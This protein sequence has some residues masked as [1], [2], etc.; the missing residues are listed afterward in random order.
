MTES[1]SDRENT[2]LKAQSVLDQVKQLA[3][4]GQETYEGADYYAHLKSMFSQ[5]YHDLFE[6]DQPITA[7]TMS[8][9]QKGLTLNFDAARSV[10]TTLVIP[11]TQ[12]P[13]YVPGGSFSVFS[14]KGELLAFDEK[15]VGKVYG[16]DEKPHNSAPYTVSK[17]LAL[18]ALKKLGMKPDIMDQQSSDFICQS[19]GL[20]PGAFHMGGIEATLPI[21]PNGKL[22][23]VIMGLSAIELTPE[24]LSYFLDKLKASGAEHSMDPFGDEVFTNGHFTAAGYLDELAGKALVSYFNG[25]STERSQEIVNQEW[26]RLMSAAIPGPLP[27]Q[28][29]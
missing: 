19:L 28:C 13:M 24:A 12:I 23:P 18:F 26:D 11:G 27:P 5:A 25:Q 21:G 6:S 3:T 16:T 29:N 15:R 2:I 10:L 14:E 22:D 17:P 4:L 1:S 8:E 7:E 9:L 20:N